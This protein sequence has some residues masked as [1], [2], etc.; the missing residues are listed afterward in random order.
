MCR[1]KPQCISIPTENV[2]EI[3]VTNARGIV[4]HGSEHWLKITRRAA[5]NLKNL[6]GRS[7]LL[8]RLSKVSGAL[9]E[10][11]SSLTQFV[12]QPRVLDG[13][14]GL[15]SEVLDQLDLLVGEWSNLLVDKS[16]LRPLVHRL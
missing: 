7:L 4:Q 11:V 15:G 3:G 5:D 6:R 16:L 1:D 10:V 2:A 12:Q 13:D 9:A 14:D 8:Q